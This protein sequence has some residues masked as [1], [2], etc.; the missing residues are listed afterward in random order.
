MSALFCLLSLLR[1][2][3]RDGLPEPAFSLSRARRL[4]GSCE[5]SWLTAIDALRQCKGEL[6]AAALL[7]MDA[8]ERQQQ[9]EPDAKAAS[10]AAHGEVAVSERTSR[11]R[12]PFALSPYLQSVYEL[13]LMNE[14]RVS[15]YVASRA[16]VM[17]DGHLS[18][19]NRILND[20]ELR[21]ALQGERAAALASC[22]CTLPQLPP[23]QAEL[24][25]LFSRHNFLLRLVE[26]VR[27]QLF[28]IHESCLH[29]AAPLPRC[30]W[31]LPVCS[32]PLCQLADAEE[33]RLAMQAAVDASPPD[34]IQAA[35]LLPWAAGLVSTCLFF[36]EL[37]RVR[38]QMDLALPPDAE[39]VQERMRQEERRSADWQQYIESSGLEDALAQALLLLSLRFSDCSDPLAFIISQLALAARSAKAEPAAAEAAPRQPSLASLFLSQQQRLQER[40]AEIEQLRDRLFQLREQREAEEDRRWQRQARHEREKAKHEAQQPKGERETLLDSEGGSRAVPVPWQRTGERRL[41]GLWR[42]LCSALTGRSAAEQQQLCLT[43]QLLYTDGGFL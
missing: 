29:C 3:L 41:S 5:C 23:E 18:A 37:Q 43:Q 35:A 7:V 2:T 25:Q 36:A 8:A 19:A 14:Q 12:P 6:H 1:D 39:A 11:L 16:L 13:H 40:D 28:V 42:S 31:Q 32:S 33:R 38:P 24:L 34:V 9:H 27:L 10:A 22:V 17:A 15:P 21:C 30:T 4:V 26:L 20:P